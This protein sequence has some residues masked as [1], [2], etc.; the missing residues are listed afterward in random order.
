MKISANEGKITLEAAKEIE[1]KCGSSK[2]TMTPSE[3]SIQ[4]SVVNV[5][6]SS[7][8][9][10]IMGTTLLTHVHGDPDIFDGVTTPGTG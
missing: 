8:N 5:T 6:G 7:G 4:G 3:I 2:I 1:F 10:S 9:V